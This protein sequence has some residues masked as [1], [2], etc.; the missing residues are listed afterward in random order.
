MSCLFQH[1]VD[2]EG[3]INENNRN[4]DNSQSENDDFTINLDK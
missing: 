3:Y 4:T 2:Y 1:K